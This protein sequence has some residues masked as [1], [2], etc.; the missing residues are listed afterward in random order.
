MLRRGQQAAIRIILF[1]A[2][3]DGLA[4]ASGWVGWF[5]DAR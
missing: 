4:A 1:K 2:K 3:K 5:T